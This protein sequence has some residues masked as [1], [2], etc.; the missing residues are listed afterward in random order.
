MVSEGS[1]YCSLCRSH[2]FSSY[3]Y[4]GGIFLG[5]GLIAPRIPPTV[6]GAST[7]IDELIEQNKDVWANLLNN[8]FRANDYN[9]SAADFDCIYKGYAKVSV[10]PNIGA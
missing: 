4:S 5:A 3:L 9:S 2:D 10:S 6:P 7:A 1:D 8:K